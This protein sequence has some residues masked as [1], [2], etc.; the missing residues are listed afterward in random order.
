MKTYNAK[1]G[2]IERRWYIVDAAG[3]P[4]GRTASAIAMILMGKT[5]PTFTPNTD[6]GDFVVAINVG[7]AVLTGKKM[8]N[9]QYHHHTG[10]VGKLFSVSAEELLETKPADMLKFAVEGM[11]P[12]SRLGKAMLKKLKVHA[13]ACPAHGYTAQKAQP[14][15]T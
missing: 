10:W 8:K 1:P 6:V 2:E 12:K 11:L 4:I 9:K 13:G 5:K 3:K 14:L 15:E 7:K